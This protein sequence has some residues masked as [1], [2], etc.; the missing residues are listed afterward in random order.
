VIVVDR[1]VPVTCT[2]PLLLRVADVIVPA[3]A[4][5]VPTWTLP[6]LE[7]VTEVSDPVTPKVPEIVVLFDNAVVP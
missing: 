2:F 1:I 4:T 7:C 6:E 3:T 5:F